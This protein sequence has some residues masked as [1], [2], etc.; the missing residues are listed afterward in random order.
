MTSLAIHWWLGEWL[1]C[2]QVLVVVLGV[3]LCNHDDSALS[4]P[5]SG[6]YLETSKRRW[7]LMQYAAWSAPGICVS[8]VWQE[9]SYHLETQMTYKTSLLDSCL[10]MQT[11]PSKES[12]G[13]GSKHIQHMHQK[14]WSGSVLSSITSWDVF[15]FQETDVFVI[16]F[17]W[18]NHRSMRAIPLPGLL[19]VTILSYNNL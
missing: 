2:A 14:P 4:W 19:T 10:V 12:V 9:V 3:V 7:R 11:Y 18:G 17:Y 8:C 16:M 1:A 13:W 6:P 15:L 5:R